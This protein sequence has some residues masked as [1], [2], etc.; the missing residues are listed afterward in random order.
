[1]ANKLLEEGASVTLR[2]SFYDSQ[3]DEITTQDVSVQLGGVDVAQQF[4]VAV[5]TEVG[6]MRYSYEVIN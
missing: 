3:G 4:Q 6:V 5:D 2:F 1:M